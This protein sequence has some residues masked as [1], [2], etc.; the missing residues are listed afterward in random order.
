[1]IVDRG[2]VKVMILS[3]GFML[4]FAAFQ[5]MSNIE[6]SHVDTD[7]SEQLCNVNNNTV[8]NNLSVVVLFM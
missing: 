2:F 5:T 6:V 8:V 7:I 3:F 1:M 4:V